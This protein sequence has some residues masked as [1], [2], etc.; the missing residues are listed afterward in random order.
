[1]VIAIERTLLMHMLS[2]HFELPRG[3]DD[4]YLPL[5]GGKV[6]VKGDNGEKL[7]IP[8]GGE[9]KSVIA[10]QHLFSDPFLGAAY[11]TE[12]AFDTMFPTQ[13]IISSRGSD[14]A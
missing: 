13:P 6:W 8:Y 4:D 11:D 3:V 9:F 5:Y 2:F 7:S 12:K 1:L 14:W 10:V